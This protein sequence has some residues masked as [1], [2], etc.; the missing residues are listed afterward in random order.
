MPVLVPAGAYLLA[1]AWVFQRSVDRGFVTNDSFELALWS[2]QAAALCLLAVGATWEWVRAQ[3]HAFR[4]GRPGRRAASAR[5]RPGRSA[6]RWHAGWEI[7]RWSCSTA[8]RTAAWSTAAGH[9]R[10]PGR[11]QQLTP[12]V[13]RGRTLASSR[14]GPG[15]SPIQ[16][17]PRRSHPPLASPSRM[18][19]CRRCCARSWRTCARRAL[20]SSRR[21]TPNAGGSSG[22]FTTAPSSGLWRCRWR[23]ASPS[24]STAATTQRSSGAQQELK[25]LLGGA[26]RA[27]ARHLPGGSRRGGPRRRRRGLWRS[28]R[29]SP[30]GCTCRVPEDR[31][32]A[33]VETAAYMIIREMVRDER[34]GGASIDTRREGDRLVLE[35]DRRRWRHP[36]SSST[37]RTASGRWVVS[38]GWSEP[39]EGVT[40]LRAELPCV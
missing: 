24:P 33:P 31:F 10:A 27:R 21:A 4:A 23:S 2:A 19:V 18:S 38:S 3:A 14:T 26:S 35:S 16:G 29:A 25:L 6:P 20:E 30:S 1:V 9:R 39:A 32:D 11:D 22:T 12:L 28:S 15:S 37:W 34:R 36:P 7:R 17:S 5:R 40:C 13:S 8:C